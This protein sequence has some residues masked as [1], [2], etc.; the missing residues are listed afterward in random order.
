MERCALEDTTA[1][2]GLRFLLRPRARTPGVDADFVSRLK[3]RVFLV[4]GGS[5]RWLSWSVLVLLLGPSNLDGSFAMVLCG[6]GV[7][8]FTGCC[9]R[10]E[11]RR[12]VSS[13]LRT[14]EPGCRTACFNLHEPRNC[15]VVQP[16]LAEQRRA[17]LHTLLSRWLPRCFSKA[18]P[19]LQYGVFASIRCVHKMWE[20]R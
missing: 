13:W 8:C 15:S 9:C 5:L 2:A 18:D 17:A 10:K 20:E 14:N 12:K 1:T 7:G 3:G 16:L 6:F 11:N 4:W 19:M